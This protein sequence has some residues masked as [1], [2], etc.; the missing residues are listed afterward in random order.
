MF[1]RKRVLTSGTNTPIKSRDSLNSNIGENNENS[2][3]NTPNIQTPTKLFYVIIT[4]LNKCLNNKFIGIC[5]SC[6]SF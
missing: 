3:S 1:Q 5:N 6:Q 2:S 4:L